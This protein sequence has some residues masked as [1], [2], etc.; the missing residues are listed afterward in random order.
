MSDRP[1]EEQPIRHP[2]ILE[3]PQL[4]L[5]LIVVLAAAIALG[6]LK[7]AGS[8]LD[9]QARAAIEQRVAIAVEIEGQRLAELL[10]EY[11]Y[12]DEAWHKLVDVPD[13]AWA[14][15]N[16]G[17]YLAESRGIDWSMVIDGNDT[18]GILFIDG[19]QED[20][21]PGTV[22][23]EEITEAVRRARLDTRIPTPVTAVLR[24][25]DAWY[26]AAVDTFTPEYDRPADGSLL[27]IA[28]QIGQS[29]VDDIS[30][31]YR[32]PGLRLSLPG[33][34]SEDSS[35][36]LLG[37]DITADGAPRMFWDVPRPS[38]SALTERRPELTG[39]AI[40]FIVLAGWFA[41]ALRRQGRLRRGAMQRLQ[42]IDSLTGIGNR[43]HFF[44]DSRP[45]LVRAAGDRAPL[46]LILIDVDRFQRVNEALGHRA[47]DNVLR[48]TVH[49]IAGRLRGYD[50]L[51][52]LG[53]NTFAALL[54]GTPLSAAQD[55]AERIRSARY[56][57]Q[58][59]PV[60]VRVGITECRDGD[61]LDE[62]LLRAEAALSAGR[63]SGGNCVISA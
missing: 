20:I 61:S 47:A 45:E 29:F 35:S 44:E 26:L 11:A 31:S 9:Q 6:A 24:F 38:R 52:R 14:D 30:K 58:S 48:E 50:I 37:G 28:R 23:G 8:L 59:P 46:C 17:T 7:E 39:A 33:D 62:M 54:P 18:P 34:S 49:T 1:L 53:D 21:D 2:V 40:G 63:E 13:P 27:L 4:P 56:R 25:R 16:I 3:R 43:D 15:D 22:A 36:V 60:T 57:Q 12:W 41:L 5:M 19:L 32:V 10:V 42:R 55:I 51:A